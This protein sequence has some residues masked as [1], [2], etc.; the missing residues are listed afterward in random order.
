MPN[1]TQRD[2]VGASDLKY[3]TSKILSKPNF[4]MP[5]ECRVGQT[6]MICC[7]IFLPDDIASVSVRKSAIIFVFVY[8]ILWQ[9][10]LFCPH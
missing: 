7:R 2:G 10:K 1:T 9:I 3:G 4:R 6:N 5:M 8:K